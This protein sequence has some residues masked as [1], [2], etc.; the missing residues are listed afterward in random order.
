MYEMIPNEL[1]NCRQWVCWRSE[2]DPKS[3]SEIKKLSIPYG[4]TDYNIIP[5]VFQKNQTIYF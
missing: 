5:T 2:P 1:K 3:Q 4:K